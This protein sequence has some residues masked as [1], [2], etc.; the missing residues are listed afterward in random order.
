MP[1]LERYRG[2]VRAKKDVDAVQIEV[3]RAWA[4]VSKTVVKW[5]EDLKKTMEEALQVDSEIKY[6]KS[7]EESL[8]DFAGKFEYVQSAT[9]KD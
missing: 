4:R 1:T 3:P 9:D 6:P 8:R 5:V 2:L 7:H